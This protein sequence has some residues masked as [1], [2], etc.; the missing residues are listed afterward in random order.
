MTV[1]EA[2]ETEG[3]AKLNVAGLLNMG[4]GGQSN[5]SSTA[6]N[7]ICFKVPLAM[8]VD[9]VSLEELQRQDQALAERRR[10]QTE[11][12]RAHNQSISARWP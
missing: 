2:T 12:I 3:K 6:T 4:T 5:A 7:R 10:R 11:Q 9:A 1:I 8:P